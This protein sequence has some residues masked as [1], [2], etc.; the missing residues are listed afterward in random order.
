MCDGEL[1]QL[2]ETSQT[3]YEAVVNG[4]DD[5]KC[6]QEDYSSDSDVMNIKARQDGVQTY[7]IVKK[8][9]SPPK[10]PRSPAGH[11]YYK[12]RQPE[13]SR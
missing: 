4:T 12:G 10:K 13:V 8:T 3:E 11:A 1:G 7:E 9:S 5:N 6:H 2:V